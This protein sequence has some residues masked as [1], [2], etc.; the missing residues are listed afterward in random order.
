[1]QDCGGKGILRL[2]QQNNENL[3]KKPKVIVHLVV[4]LNICTTG[5][6]EKEI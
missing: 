3:S 4:T 2:A 1:M 5:L 6:L